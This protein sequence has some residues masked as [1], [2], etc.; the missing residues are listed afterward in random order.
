MNTQILSPK[1]IVFDFD[2]TIADTQAL[3]LS[4]FRATYERLG[5][6]APAAD[7]IAATI[8][9]PLERA[10]QN[11][12][13]FT[14]TEAREVAAEYRRLFDSRVKEETLP[15]EGMPEV[16]KACAALGRPLAVASSRGRGSLIPMIEALGLD[17]CFD[18]VVGRE[19]VAEEK[20]DPALLREIARRLQVA[21]DELLM[22]GDTYYDLEMARRAGAIAVG[23]TFGNH[24]REE[25]SRAEPA[26]IVERPAEIL[27][28]LGVEQ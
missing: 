24:S 7:D 10:F 23:V 26:A 20:P 28:L 1:A 27:Q 4:S 22:I 6:P 11:L 8:G 12:S 15:I 5:R 17:G 9:L 19:D 13:G 25:L 21:P 14:E 3:I 16:V 2:G 18:V